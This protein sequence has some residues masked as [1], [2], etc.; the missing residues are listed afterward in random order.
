MSDG[1]ILSDEALDILFREARSFNEWQDKEASAVTL[2]AVFDLMK[3]APTSANCFP[4]RVVFV[5][6][7]EA[8]AR[9]KPHLAEGNVD[10]TMSA[11]AVAIMA[12]DKQFYEKLPQLFPHADAKSWFVGNQA[13][14]DETAMRNGTLQGAYLML[15]AR[16]LGL[17][18]GPMSGFDPEGMKAEFFP[19]QDYEVNF[20]C[21]LGYGDRETLFPRSPRPDFD[22]MA[23]IL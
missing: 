21:N 7:P 1:K 19:G 5:T 9:L 13:L 6:S 22:D 10:K 15:A 4:L 16:A 3:W 8:K 23:D 20:I 12:N 14:I 17:D 2:R 11:P 18:C